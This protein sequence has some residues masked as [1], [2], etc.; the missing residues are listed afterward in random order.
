MAKDKMPHF[1]EEAHEI[2]SLWQNYAATR[3]FQNWI[4]SFLVKIIFARGE[5]LSISSIPDG[6]N[7][8]I[9]KALQAGK[10]KIAIGKCGVDAVIDEEGTPFRNIAQIVDIR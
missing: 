8:K 10:L 2:V 3:R 5:P 1:I 4:V 7:E 6:D 9:D